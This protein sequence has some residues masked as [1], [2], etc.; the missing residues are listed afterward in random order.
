[1]TTNAQTAMGVV[2]TFDVDT[3][4]EI[5]SLTGARSRRIIDILSCDS[6]NQAVE[7]IAGALNEGSATMHLIYDGSAAGVYNK[8][9]THLQSKTKAALL[10]TYPDTSNHSCTALISSLGLPAFNEADGDIEL[11]VTFEF[12]GQATYTD[13]P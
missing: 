6:T 9:N 4:G 13:V 2:V 3:I 8:L 11:D 10:I 5:M 7:K 12:S 1:M